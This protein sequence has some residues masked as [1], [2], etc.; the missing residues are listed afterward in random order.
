M[1]PTHSLVMAWDEGFA[2]AQELIEIMLTEAEQGDYANS[3]RD[4]GR[5]VSFLAK[6]IRERLAQ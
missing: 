5:G 6:T 3:S 1:E 2:H 4:F